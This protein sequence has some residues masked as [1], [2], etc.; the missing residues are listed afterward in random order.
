MSVV[1]I[2]GLRTSNFELYRSLVNQVLEIA[3]EEMIT[4]YISAEYELEDITGAVKYIEEKKC[5][6]KV[7]IKVLDD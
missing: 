6:G 1:N 3:D 4:A 5:T 2:E 7:L